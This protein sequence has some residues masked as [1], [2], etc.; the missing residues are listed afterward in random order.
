MKR[1]PFFLQINVTLLLFLQ[2]ILLFFTLP[3]LS[4]AELVDKVVAVVNDDVITLSEVENEAKPLYQSIARNYEGPY[5]TEEL[6][7]ARENTLDSM[8]SRRLIDQKA[9]LFHLKVSEKEIDNG[10]ERM[11]QRSSLSPAEF[12]KKLAESGMSEEVYRTN[13]RSQILQS[14]LVSFDVRSK[15]VITDEMI[16]DYYDENY[17]SRV[18]KGN[19]YLLQMG[20][21]WNKKSGSAEDL[22][23]SKENALKKAERV[24]KLVEKGEDF[25][26]LAKKFS[27]LPSAVDGGDIGIFTL[28]EMASA[29]RDAVA[30]LKHG[31]LSKIV[32]TPTEYQFYKLLS[33]K[34]GSIV[35]T[36]SY[37][38]V[39]D[40]IK[41]KLYQVKLKEAFTGWVA[42]L[43]KKAY[44]QKL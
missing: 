5:L 36:A 20:F 31:Q 35:V 4:Q 28:D 10:Y 41:E 13:I 25:R 23:L 30:H 33:E 8:I 9:A 21:T 22:V 2:I 27:D 38:S 37:D 26:T 6:E 19:Y 39:K 29:M 14:K 16:L 40:E 15:V 3:H 44:I 1:F 17:T 18:K 7:K 12:R 32:E 11:R 42:D 24:R 34:D 43:K